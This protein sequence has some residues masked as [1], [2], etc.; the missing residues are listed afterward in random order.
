MDPWQLLNKCY[1]KERMIFVSR[2]MKAQ[3]NSWTD[4]VIPENPA[5]LP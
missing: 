5:Y 2:L 1:V 4:H 3:L